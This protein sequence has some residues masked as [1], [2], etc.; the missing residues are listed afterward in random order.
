MGKT[1]SSYTV[2]SMN[3]PTVQKTKKKKKEK[4]HSPNVMQITW[5]WLGMK[6][7]LTAFYR[8][9]QS[10]GSQTTMIEAEILFPGKLG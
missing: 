6:S 2:E 10:T 4:P 8:D 1:I 9:P 7:Q 3:K 5:G